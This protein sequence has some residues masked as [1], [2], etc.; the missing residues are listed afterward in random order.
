[1]L[2]RRDADAGHVN[3]AAEPVVCGRRE[4]VMVVMPALAERW[5]GQQPVVGGLVT[6][7]KRAL[8]EDVANGVDAPRDVVADEDS[9]QASPDQS[10]ERSLPSTEQAAD[11]KR[12]SK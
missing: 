6:G 5:Q 3:L 12:E 10:G 9:Y 1:A 11:R 2:E 8:P 4:D 7:E